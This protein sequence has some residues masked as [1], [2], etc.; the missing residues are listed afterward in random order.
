MACLVRSVRIRVNIGVVVKL[1]FRFAKSRVK[2]FHCIY[3][4][5]N[6]AITHEDMHRKINRRPKICFTYTGSQ[7]IRN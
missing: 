4:G 2:S 3:T 6:I 1:I 5:K 7:F